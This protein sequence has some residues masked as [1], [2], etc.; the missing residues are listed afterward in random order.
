M[1]NTKGRLGRLVRAAEDIEAGELVMMEEAVATCLLPQEYPGRCYCCLNKVAAPVPCRQCRAIV[2]CSEKCEQ[3]SWTDRGHCIECL[4]TASL[5]QSGVFQVALQLLL[6]GLKECP[7]FWKKT[8][9]SPRNQPR[10]TEF[11]NDY[12]SCLR[13]HIEITQ[14]KEEE[15]KGFIYFSIAITRLLQQTNT[16]DP[17]IHDLQHISKYLLRHAIQCQLN[18]MCL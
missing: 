14:L 7:D 10:K 8:N 17:E 5:I 4:F 18:A 13:S 11:S 1:G 12:V 6:V 2:Y 3:T 9:Q 15:L 16:I